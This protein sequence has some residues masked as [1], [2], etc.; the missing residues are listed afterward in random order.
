VLSEY[1]KQIKEKDRVLRRVIDV[2]V[3][4]TGLGFRQALQW[5]LDERET[6]RVLLSKQRGVMKRILDS[7]IRLMSAG[8]NKLCEEAK[9]R[10]SQLKSRLRGILKSLSDKDL[11]YKLTAYNSMKQRMQMLNSFGMGTADT[12]KVQMIKRLTSQ[13]HNLQVMAVNSL[14][15]FLADERERQELRRLQWEQQQRDKHRILYRIMDSN[16]RMSGIAFRQAHQWTLDAR[17]YERIRIFKQR[18]V[19]RRILDANAR[20][21]SAGYNKL[22]ESSKVNREKLQNK[23]KGVIKSL[24]DRDTRFLIT[25]YNGL[26]QRYLMLSGQGMATAHMKKIQLIKRM[27]NQSH[28]FQVMAVNA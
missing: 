19:M 21:L 16:L 24:V 4:L 5:T 1:L 25:A 28:N 7:N 11:S 17:E 27:T 3:R 6:E 26:K 2:T 20:L 12:L 13:S 8:Y 23:L 10:K 14:R 9:M 15:E 22:V 18:G